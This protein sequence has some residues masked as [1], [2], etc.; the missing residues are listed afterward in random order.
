[1]SA[2][3]PD[4]GA[5]ARSI[6][7]ETKAFI[8]G[9]FVDAASGKSFETINPATG[10]ALVSIAAGDKEDVDRAVSAARAVFEKGDWSNQSPRDRK[11]ALLKLADLIEKNQA[12]L[13][14]LEALDTGKPVL[15]AFNADLPD[16]IA[17]MRWH[18]EAIDKIYDS[19]SPTPSDIVS[20]V[21][22]EP[23]GVVGAVIPWNFPLAITAMKIGPVLAGGNSIVIKPAEQTPLTALKLA[24]LAAEAGIPDGVINVVPGFGETAGQAIGR[25]RDVDCLSFT[26]STEVGGYFLKYAAESNLKRVILEL[27]GKSPVIV[28]DDVDDLTPIVEQIA[29]GI[30]FSQ[31][32]NCSAGSRLLVQ[33]KMKDRLLEA[34]IE[35]FKT[36]KVGDPFAADTRMGALIEEKHLNR[37]LGYIDAGRKEGASIVL[38]GNQVLKETGGYFVEPTI[39]DN[40]RND[41]KI[42]QEEIFGPV[43]AAIT[44]DDVEDAVRIANDTKFGLAASLYTNDLHIAHKVSRKIRAGT[45]S[46]NC[47]SEG[48]QAVPFGGF[49]QSGFGGREKSM[50][51]HDQYMQ[52]KTIWMQLR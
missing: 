14:V 28:M 41:M 39:F 17:T 19:I 12:E 15:D 25:H 45:V 13:A 5:I 40:V 42:A 32:E 27:G 9:K 37:V 18:A 44:F 2:T 43:L 4:F 21:V 52:T 10:K 1:M 11:I 7:Y 50:L 6:E 24:R 8:N 47:F 22:R 20:M 3:S 35:H 16:A 36:W 46:V 23:I 26:G 49:K 38:G 29:V 31:G 34:V 48:D 30:L 51:A 33:K